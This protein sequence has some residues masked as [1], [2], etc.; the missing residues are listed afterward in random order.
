MIVQDG[1]HNMVSAL[2]R[3]VIKHGGRIALKQEVTQIEHK[4]DLN[5][6][7]VR[8]K[9]GQTFDSPLCICTLPLGVLKY[10]PPV[11]Q[12]PLPPRRQRAIHNLG[13]GLLNKVV[14][15]YPEVWWELQPLDA[16]MSAIIPEDHL[17]EQVPYVKKAA[18]LVQPYVHLTDGR[19]TLLFYLGVCAACSC[20]IMR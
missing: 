8:T 4:P 16:A 1:Y 13:F 14:V 12:P 3:L 17:T 9:Q 10:R 18:S 2:E 7:A 15:T 6:V 19:P 20:L 5:R 11:F